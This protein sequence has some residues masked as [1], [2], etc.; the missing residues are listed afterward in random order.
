MSHF[1][2]TLH[3][4]V[5]DHDSVTYFQTAKYMLKEQIY[6]QKCKWDKMLTIVEAVSRAFCFEYQDKLQN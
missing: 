2:G 6:K 3:L 1:L 4:G 5:K